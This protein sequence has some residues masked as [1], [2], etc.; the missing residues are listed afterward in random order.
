MNILQDTVENSLLT[1]EKNLDILPSMQLLENSLLSMD[2]NKY[3]NFMTQYKFFNDIFAP[4]VLHL[5]S[6]IHIEMNSIYKNSIGSEIAAGVYN[7]CLHEY[8]ED[9]NGKKYTHGRLSDIFITELNSIIRPSKINMEPDYLTL[10]FIKLVKS[11][12]GI[13]LQDLPES[14]VSKSLGFH[15]ASELLASKE[16][17]I[18][19][20]ITSIKFP[21]VYNAMQSTEKLGISPWHWIKIHSTVEIEHYNNAVDSYKKS[22]GFFSDSYILHGIENFYDIQMNFIESI[23]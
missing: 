1:I 21:K 22:K 15:M 14:N 16:F 20:R 23:S 13:I 2:E 8:G 7:A 17:E 19:D 4:C 6:E 3:L 10:E 18:I 11:G 9:V 5:A 12:Y